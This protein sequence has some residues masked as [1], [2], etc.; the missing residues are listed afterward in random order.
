MLIQKNILR[1][2]SSYNKHFTVKNIQIY[3]EN[4][5]KHQ[6]TQNVS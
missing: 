4:N 6:N 2:V 5:K 1:R 3:L